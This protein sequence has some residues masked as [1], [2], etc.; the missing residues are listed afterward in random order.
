MVTLEFLAKVPIFENLTPEQLQPLGEKMRPR[1]FQRGEVVF[2]QDDPGDRM[3]IIVQGRVR[4]SLD[5][6]DGREKDVALLRPGE[7]FGEMSLLDGS[8]RSAKATAVDD[9]ETLVLMRDDYIG[10]LGEYPEVAAQTTA[11]L[12][13]RLRNANQML[14]DMAFLDVPTRVAKQ[15]IELAES[16]LEGADPEGAIEISI[17][18]DELAR[19]VGSSRETVSRALTS[20]R[21]MGLL[22]TFHRRISITDLRGLARMAS[23]G[24]NPS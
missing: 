4:I 24:R 18:Q 5:S 8:N 2:H 15:L 16:Q 21:R 11:V 9:I 14:G 19:L 12:T 3:H 1:K 13:N 7:C 22:T 17:G 23:L 20:Y 10:F 6:D